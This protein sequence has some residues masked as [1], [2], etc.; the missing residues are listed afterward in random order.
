M[1]SFWSLIKENENLKILSLQP[2]KSKPSL[3]PPQQLSACHFTHRR[4]VAAR[5]THTT[6]VDNPQHS[7]NS[8]SLAENFPS[9]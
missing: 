1:M 8:Q 3:L 2:P 9:S 4:H 6:P 7:H 5:D